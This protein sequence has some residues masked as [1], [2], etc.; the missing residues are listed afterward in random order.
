MLTPP[1]FR[2]R[3]HAGRL[4]AQA[5]QSYADRR[6]VLVLALP[7]G[8]VPVGFEV[9]RAL[10]APLDVLVVRKLGVPGHAEYA[11]G[12]IASGGIRLLN[13]EVVQ[14]MEVT[15]A[16]IDSTVSAESKELHRREQAYRGVRPPLAAAGRTVILV[17]DGMATGSTM[18]AAVRALRTL[19]PAHIAVA[20]PTAAADVCARLRAEADEVICTTTPE[21]FRA[22]GL[23]YADFSQTSDD[24]VRELLDEAQAGGGPDSY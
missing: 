4:L 10:R 14:G 16:Q 21:P 13:D 17:D 19:R 5:L 9:A 1:L 7:R 6:D 2:D 12:A 23:W 20:V 8:G 24:E 18:L 11:M 3:R 15:K 22:V